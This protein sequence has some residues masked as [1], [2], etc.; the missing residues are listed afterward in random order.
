M[1]YSKAVGWLS[2]EFVDAGREGAADMIRYREKIKNAEL[3]MLNNC[4]PPF[5]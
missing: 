1:E 5:R 2:N 4:L 3:K